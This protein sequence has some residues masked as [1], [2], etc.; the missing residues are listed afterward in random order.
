MVF[1]AEVRYETAVYV[2]R[3]LKWHSSVSGVG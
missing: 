2:L 3:L 1:K